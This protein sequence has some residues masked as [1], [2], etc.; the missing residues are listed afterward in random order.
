MHEPAGRR[1]P[2]A[3]GRSP[4][5]CQRSSSI[6]SSRRAKPTTSGPHDP[7]AVAGSG[8]SHRGAGDEPACQPERATLAGGQTRRPCAAR[9]ASRRRPAAS[10]AGSGR[11]GELS[12]ELDRQIPALPAAGIPSPTGA[13]RRSRRCDA[14]DRRPPARARRGSS[15]APTHRVAVALEHLDRLRHERAGPRDAMRPTSCGRSLSPTVPPPR[16]LIE[17]TARLPREV[18]GRRRRHAVRDDEHEDLPSAF[19]QR[20]DRLRLRYRRF[21]RRQCLHPAETHVQ[22]CT[23]PAASVTAR[24]D[25]ERLF[26]TA[27]DSRHHSAR[28]RDLPAGDPPSEK[29]PL[30][31]CLHYRARDSASMMH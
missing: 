29:S 24:A 6:P 20:R 25:I 28:R 18:L 7:T 1:R 30:A 15:R 9:G 22:K 12:R 11:L 27:P 21:S 26:Y 10:G 8:V 31:H 5:R 3:R 16:E 14:C 23:H 17:A 4:G 13:I 2:R 19:A